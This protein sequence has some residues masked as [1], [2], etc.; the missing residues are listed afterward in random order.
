MSS[1]KKIVSRAVQTSF[2]KPIDVPVVVEIPKIPEVPVPEV[3]VPEL[4]V[5]DV[6]EVSTNTLESQ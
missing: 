6:Q 1:L 4:Q 3:P 5:V 2:A